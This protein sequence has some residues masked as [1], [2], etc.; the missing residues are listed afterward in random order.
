MKKGILSLA[1]ASVICTGN[2]EYNSKENSARLQTT[3]ELNFK[4]GEK[5]LL[6]PV[7]DVVGLD[8]RTFRI[9]GED[10]IKNTKENGVDLP[11][12]I[13]HGWD[14]LYGG[15]AAGWIDH[16][17]LELREDGIYGLLKRTQLGKELIEGLYYRYVSPAYIMDRNKEDRTVLSLDSI[18]L[19]NTPNL[20]NRALNAKDEDLKS[21]ISSLELEKN[22]AM[23]TADA[24]AKELKE[25]NAKL[26]E[27]NNKVETIQENL[28]TQ[29]E[30]NKI[31]KI[32]LAIEQNKILPKDKEFCK[33]LT[34]QQLDSYIQNNA[35]SDLAKELGFELNPKEQNSKDRVKIAAAA[36]SK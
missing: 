17:S 4:Q 32:N 27:F 10:V 33:T 15:K 31:L 3:L 22:Q 20:V 19:V 36:G 7:G 11:L 21:K 24:T 14:A 26:L 16:T 23:D 28:K 25:T 12:E 5:I 35:G 13:N 18:G 30:A 29:L 1:A 9:N 2:V 6:S 8:G 34:T